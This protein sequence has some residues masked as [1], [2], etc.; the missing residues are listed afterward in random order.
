M[1]RVR[2]WLDAVKPEQALLAPLAVAVGSAYAVF[3]A[4]PGSG[5]AGFLLVAPAA[6]LAGCGVNLVDHAWDRMGAPSDDPKNPT[7]ESE[8]P[9]DGREAVVAAAGALAAAAVLGLA[10]APW[11]GGAWLGDGA[12]AIALG[13]V[14][15]APG[16]GP[17]TI[18]FGLGELANVLALGPLAVLAGFAAAAGAGSSGAFL[19]G[20]PA[21]V[22]AAAPL[23]ARHFARPEA[24]ARLLRVTPVVSLGHEQA[25]A[26]LVA[27]PLV[28]A[29]AVILLARAGEYPAWS[30]V[31]VV[32]MAV[33][34]AAAWRTPVT[35][36]ATAYVRWSRVASICAAA[37]LACLAAAL[38][39]ASRG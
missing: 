28:A 34:A 8:R 38:R 19:A 25:R 37:A 13:A 21:G 39:F 14:R 4:R 16:L 29:A 27:F 2:P 9:L 23:F 26:L 10:S 30:R 36:D 33:A 35:P 12:L 18:G 1:E 24:D 20:V 5:V 7:P 32:P 6:F 3:D 22:I 15:G 17:D 31:A 11:L